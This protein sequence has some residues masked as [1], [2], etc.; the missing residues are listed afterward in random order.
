MIST[1]KA[2]NFTFIDFIAS[3]PYWPLQGPVLLFNCRP[4]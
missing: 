4:S 1:N 2:A 3:L